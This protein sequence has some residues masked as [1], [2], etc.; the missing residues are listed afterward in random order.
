MNQEYKDGDMRRFLEWRTGILH[1]DVTYL[2]T[3]GNHTGND[4]IDRASCV[5]GSRV[6]QYPDKMR[7]ALQERGA[8]L[9]SPDPF[10]VSAVRPEGMGVWDSLISIPRDPSLT[11]TD[12]FRNVGARRNCNTVWINEIETAIRHAGPVQGQSQRPQHLWIFDLRDDPSAWL[13]IEAAHTLTHQRLDSAE[14]ARLD[15]IREFNPYPGEF[16]RALAEIMLGMKLG[17]PINVSVGKPSRRK[18]AHMP[19]GL[20]V[21]VTPYWHT[22]LLRF[23]W[24]GDTS[25]VFDQTLALVDVGVFLQPIPSR[26]EI[27]SR[28][29]AQG[30][31]WSCLPTMLVVAGWE[32][33]DVLARQQLVVLRYESGSSS[34]STV[35]HPA[36]LMPPNTL[37]QYVELGGQ[38]GYALPDSGEWRHVWNWMQ[39]PE[40]AHAYRQTPP[41]PCPFCMSF[42]PRTEGNPPRPAKRPF[43]FKRPRTNRAHQYRDAIAAQW[44]DYASEVKAIRNVI[45]KATVV[46]ETEL[47]GGNVKIARCIRRERKAAHKS[48]LKALKDKRTLENAIH[49]QLVTGN[50]MGERERKALAAWQA[51]GGD[52]IELANR[53]RHA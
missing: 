47:R 27:H 42:N 32:S 45:D 51:G 48:K 19:Y 1:G 24:Q 39:S 49:K 30:G 6:A 18:C 2:Q 31:H 7:W 28:Q 15:P 17:I 44:D 3:I 11:S 20:D 21:S 41:L 35:M 5:Y 40:Y 53:R 52:I 13:V 22:P 26:S 9:L 23:P 46:Y 25:P 36:D 12:T 34:R 4:L 33:V 38:H 50:P 10:V 29:P 16:H 8:G 43:K 37:P 14:H